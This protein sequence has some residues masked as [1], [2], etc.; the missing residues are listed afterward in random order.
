MNS[1]FRHL[2]FWK[3]VFKVQY[4]TWYGCSWVIEN[5]KKS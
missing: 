1:V 3:P 4:G 5:V 2:P